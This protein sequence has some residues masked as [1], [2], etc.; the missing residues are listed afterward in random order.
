MM[1]IACLLLLGAATAI[2]QE[3]D[4]SRTRTQRENPGLME[5]QRPEGQNTD[6]YRS[7]DELPRQNTPDDSAPTGV[8]T[9]TQRQG[10]D[11]GYSADTTESSTGSQYQDAP[12]RQSSGYGSGL[13]G[14]AAGMAE[15]DSTNNRGSGNDALRRRDPDR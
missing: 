14:D 2:A 9:P 4:T 10:D 6:Q 7:D 1:T 15:D 8:T 3:G 13:D 12:Q 5:R 11:S